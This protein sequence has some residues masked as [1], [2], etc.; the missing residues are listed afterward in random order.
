LKE[1]YKI[2]II[3]QEANEKKLPVFVVEV[4]FVEGSY[5][6]FVLFLQ[7]DKINLIGTLLICSEIVGK[8]DTGIIKSFHGWF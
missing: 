4:V 7:V 2:K 5:K 6:I 8:K 3:G 1:H